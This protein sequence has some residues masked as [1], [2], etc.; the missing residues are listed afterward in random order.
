MPLHGL[1]PLGRLPAVARGR[2][3][4]DEENS[5]PLDESCNYGSSYCVDTQDVAKCEKDGSST[6]SP[7]ETWEHCVEVGG[8]AACVTCG[9]RGQPCCGGDDCDEGHVCVD[10][11]EG[12][13]C[14]PTHEARGAG[15]GCGD[16][17]C[18]EDERCLQGAG[19]PTCLSKCGEEH[20]S[21]CYIGPLSGHPSTSECSGTLVCFSEP[22]RF[23][24][25]V[26]TGGFQETCEKPDCGTERCTLE[27]LCHDADGD[28]ETTSDRDCRM[29]CGK[30]GE[31][32]CGDDRPLCEEGLVRDDDWICRMPNCGPELACLSD[33]VCIVA[34]DSVSGHAYHCTR[35]GK[36]CEATGKLFL[37]WD[38]KNVTHSVTSVKW[39]C[40]DDETCTT[41]RDG[42]W[43]ATGEQVYG[44]R[45]TKPGAHLCPDGDVDHICGEYSACMSCIDISFRWSEE[46][47][48]VITEDPVKGSCYDGVSAD[49]VCTLDDFEWRCPKIDGTTNRVWHRAT[50]TVRIGIRTVLRLRASPKL[51]VHEVV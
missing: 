14:Q 37:T 44:G 43:N 26:P 39:S 31:P 6:I 46:D 42:H 36:Q 28:D 5:A 38:S 29:P 23:V 48:S 33:Q 1:S 50:R 16:D 17:I 3:S 9:K 40:A 7:C 41:V 25:G 18:E 35:S 4:G 21:C 8:D 13:R 11:S 45:C 30:E 49:P 51:S 24:D 2:R 32:T 12:R 27:E 19:G 22:L 47:G 34:G 20:E 10:V 15:T